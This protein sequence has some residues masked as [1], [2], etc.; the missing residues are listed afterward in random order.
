M[1]MNANRSR[2]LAAAIEARRAR[3][4]SLKVRHLSI[5]EIQAALA[6]EGHVNP[7]TKRAW[8]LGI[9]VE[10]LQALEAQWRAETK[11]DVAEIIAFE[12]AKLDETEREARAAWHRGIGK[13]K[14][15]HAERKTGTGADGTATSDRT[16]VTTTDLNGDP[17]YLQ[18]IHDCQERRAALLGLDAPKRVD[19]TITAPGVMLV[20]MY[21]S[22]EEWEKAAVAAQEKL[23][24]ETGG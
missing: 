3:V 12:L 11:R 15:E 20:P 16:Y 22:P 23:A 5:R 6:S 8:S 9:L 14:K 7:R 17:R 4:A 1:G 18:V 19:A 21:G 2:Q 10:D 24:R 13:K